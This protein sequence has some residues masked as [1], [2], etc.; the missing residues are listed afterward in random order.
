M[1]TELWDLLR[2]PPAAAAW[3][4]ALDELLML[5]AE[6]VGRPTLRFYSW[7]EPAATFG[8]FQRSAEVETWTRLRPLIR[9]PT[10][11]GLVPHDVDWTYSLAFPPGHWWYESK[12]DLSYQRLHDWVAGAFGR[13]SVPAVLAPCCEKVLPGQ[14]FSGAEKSD[15][16]FQGRK[17]AGAAQRRSKQALLIQ[18]SVQP[19]PEAPA[20]AAWEQAMLDSAG[21]RF[22][23]RFAEVSLDAA[24]LREVAGLAALKYSGAEHN[25]KR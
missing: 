21:E 1:A 18:G 14:C 10:G 8:Y 9:R 22:G 2:T 25:R 12:A 16:L 11:G 7:A 23:A 15:L 19:P 17:I 20:R 6:A 4:M 3:N 5:R 24:T 13:L